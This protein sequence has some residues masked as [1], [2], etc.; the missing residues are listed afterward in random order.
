MYY[1][2]TFKAIL[3]LCILFWM[4]I[5]PCSHKINLKLYNYK[6]NY[7]LIIYLSKFLKHYFFVFINTCTSVTLS[8]TGHYKSVS[9]NIMNVAFK[10]LT[11]YQTLTSKILS[12]DRYSIKH[13]SR[14]EFQVIMKC[15]NSHYNDQYILFIFDILLFV[16]NHVKE[17]GPLSG[18]LLQSLI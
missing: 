7:T 2:F 8:R 14:D 4:V 9:S 16:A 10:H 1:F 17:K 12:C 5:W 15:P 3:F 11:I 13:W 6:H 18:T